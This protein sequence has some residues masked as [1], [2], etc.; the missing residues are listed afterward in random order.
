MRG[1]V[2]S[3]GGGRAFLDFAAGEE[4]DLVGGYAGEGHFVGDQDEVAAFAL[5]F[6]DHFEDLGGH[7]GVEGGGGLVEEEQAGLDGDGAG[8]G[9]A[10]FLAAAELGG[11]FVGVGFEL[12]ALEGFHGARECLG[13]REAVDF[14]EGEH[15]VIERGE[16]G[17]EVVGLE[18]GADLAAVFAEG[19]LVARERGAIDGDGAGVWAFKA[20]ED[21]E[22]GGFPAAAG[23]DEDE[24]V[25]RREIEGDVVEDAMGAEAFGN[26]G[27]FESHVSKRLR[28]SSDWVQREMGRVRTR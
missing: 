17:E 8:D 5:E 16:M 2:K 22:E 28:R 3:C 27:E 12:E 11:L 18:D 20:G 19:F 1:A 6:L 9:Y 26:A 7:L 24:G 4:G 25:D 21:A 10:L 15:D 13:A 14:F 23:A